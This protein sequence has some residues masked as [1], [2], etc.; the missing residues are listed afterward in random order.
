MF[1]TPLDCKVVFESYRPEEKQMLDSAVRKNFT[2]NIAEQLLS[3]RYMII[4]ETANGYS[5]KSLTSEN[6]QAFRTSIDNNTL[7]HQIN[8]TAEELIHCSDSPSKA[9]PSVKYFPSVAILR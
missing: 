4:F 7:D 9:L 6:F 2:P 1:A 3:K 8:R 5:S